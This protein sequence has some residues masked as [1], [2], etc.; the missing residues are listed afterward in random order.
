[1]SQLPLGVLS[2]LRVQ[3]QCEYASP[4]CRLKDG[5]VQFTV[6]RHANQVE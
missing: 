3:L 6:I 2:T 1:M 4:G 5:H